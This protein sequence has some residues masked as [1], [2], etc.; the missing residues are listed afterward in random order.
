[1][2]ETAP[3]AQTP[4]GKNN[5]FLIGLVAL[6]VL[7]VLGLVVFFAKPKSASAPAT[8]HQEATS[9]TPQ[10]A[11]VEVT[12]EASPTTGEVM[13][14][15]EKT[16]TID[17]SNFKFNPSEITVKKGDTVKVIFKNSGGTHNFM[18]DEF[19]VSSQTISSGQTEEVSFVAN[20]AGTFEYYCSVGTHRQQ[21]MVGKLVVE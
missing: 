11:Q 1:M 3:A 6:V 19:N 8:T 15:G 10:G 20:K 18:I 13:S 2:D 7:V 17:G 16:F 5:M 21:G 4:Q 14:K 9:P 12:Q